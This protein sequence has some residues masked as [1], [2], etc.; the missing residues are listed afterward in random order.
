MKSVDVVN[1][2]AVTFPTPAAAYVKVNLLPLE[3]LN[4]SGLVVVAWRLA[5]AAA[6]EH[7]KR[8]EPADAMA[9]VSTQRYCPSAVIAM[10]LTMENSV[11][12]P[13]VGTSFPVPS[14]V[15]DPDGSRNEN[16]RPLLIA[17]A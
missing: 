2:P 17:A 5:L 1:A 13:V 7:S 6:L 3:R 14:L 9:A 11:P 16:G 12:C 15:N 10:P 8:S 4:E